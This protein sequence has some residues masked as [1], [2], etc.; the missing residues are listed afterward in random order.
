MS[1]ERRTLE[2]TAEQ[3]AKGYKVYDPRYVPDVTTHPYQVLAY[4]KDGSATVAPVAV[5][6]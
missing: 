4:H 5:D 2:V 1:A 6:R 3:L